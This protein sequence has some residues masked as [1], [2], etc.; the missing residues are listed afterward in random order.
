MRRLD[1]QKSLT[2]G[3]LI[4]IAA[5]IVLIVGIHTNFLVFA[6]GELLIG[7][8]APFVIVPM[9]TVVLASVEKQF[10]GMASATLNTF[11]QMG[12]A[13]GVAI[14]GTALGRKPTIGAMQTA[15]EIL[16]V[17]FVLGFVLSASALGRK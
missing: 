13:L 15:I 5:S 4:G 8:G 14:L 12:G 7:I 2:I 1:S 11:R 6:L 3:K 17:A 9:A 10:S 16:L